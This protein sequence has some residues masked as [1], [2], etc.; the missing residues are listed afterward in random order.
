MISIVK[1]GR[2]PPPPALHL[3]ATTTAPGQTVTLQQITHS[4]PTAID[5]GDGVRSQVAANYA[6]THTHVYAATG[7]YAITVHKARAITALDLEDAQLSC[8]GGTVGRL[9]GLTFL[10]LK[11]LPV[12]IGRGEIGGLALLGTLSMTDYSG[13]SN[14]TVGAGEIGGLKNL[15]FLTV[16]SLSGV[17]V[18][19]GEVGGLPLLA[20][21]YLRIA[22][23]ITI[24]AGELGGLSASLTFIMLRSVPSV[25]PSAADFAALTKLE[26]LSYLNSLS[27]ATVDALMTAIYNARMSYTYAS[28]IACDISTT[29]GAPTGAVQAPAPCPPANVGEM[30]YEQAKDTCGSGHK[31]WSVTYNGGVIAP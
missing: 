2:T 1:R 3:T 31:C 13:L 6:G 30:I 19:A 26:N 28:T 24:G 27:T 4:V 9:R 15:T 17:T 5:W 18:G 10:V 20:R 29:N 21:L 14:I 12:V 25:T 7:V 22:N 8:A 11:N 23:G 16:W